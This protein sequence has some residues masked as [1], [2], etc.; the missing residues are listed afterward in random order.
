M[1]ESPSEPASRAHPRSSLLARLGALAAGLAVAA[2]LLVVARP[3]ISAID[4]AEIDRISSYA[5]AWKGALLPGSDGVPFVLAPS[6]TRGNLLVTNALGLRSPELPPRK[7]LPRILVLGDSVAFGWG[8]LEGECFAARLGASLLG[9]ADVVNAGIM[10]YQIQDQAA[11]LA[12]LAPLVEA[13]LVISTFVRN[14]L[15]DS[16]VFGPGGAIGFPSLDDLGSGFFAGGSNAQRLASNAGLSGPVLRRYLR[17]HAGDT[18]HPLRS[19]GPFARARWARNRS[20][21]GRMRDLAL[22]HGGRFVSFSYHA[23]PLG[24]VRA[25]RELGVPLFDAGPLLDLRRPDLH[26]AGDAH[27]NAR[28]HALLAD[29]LL[30]VIAS[31]GIVE[32]PLVEPAAPHVLAAEEERALEEAD[33]AHALLSLEPRILFR[34][35]AD[36]ENLD[37]VL[38]GFEDPG[39]LLGARAVVL[40]AS[41]RRI[42]ALRIVASGSLRKFETTR[43]LEARLAGSDH[44]IPVPVSRSGADVRIPL[45]AA[46][47]EPLGRSGAVL[48]QLDLRDPMVSAG[49]D[50]LRASLAS[51]RVERIELE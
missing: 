6:V 45:D 15:D 38:G 22:E 46:C 7:T 23:P 48:V 13:D 40:L 18:E 12:R 39:G 17:Q 28:A 20:G 51:V 33:V 5:S 1:S 49:R 9:R 26:L 30:Q 43:V 4:G 50:R 37:Q 35:G 10:G 2:A 42:A 36:G 41:G 44:V 19:I 14:D 11:Q 16:H 24:L 31:T 32:P 8:V 29:R 3:W 21:L 47:W 27:P 34:D 25:C